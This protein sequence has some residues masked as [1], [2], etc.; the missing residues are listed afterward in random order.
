MGAEGS[1]ERN[2]RVPFNR[3]AVTGDEL[4]LV[5]EAL[6]SGQ[7]SGDGRYSHRCEQLLGEI[8]EAPGRVLL[9][10]SGTQALEMCALLI[11]VGPGDEVIG[12][13][14]TFPSTLGAFALHGA[15]PRFADISGESL[16]IDPDEIERLLGPATK[17]IVVTHYG[18]IACEMDRILELADRHGVPVVEDSAHGLFASH[19]GRPLGTMG[20]C[21]ILSFHETKNVTSGGEGGALIMRDADDLARAEM[22]REKGTNR[23]AFFR[24]EVDAY[25]WEELGSNYLLAEP[26]AAYLLAQLQARERI[27]ESRRRAW[28]VYGRELAGWAA[29]AGV[30]LPDEPANG[31]HPWHIFWMLMPDAASRDAMLVH[32]SER[33]VH[34]VFH[35][36]PLHLSPM[37]RRLAPDTG[38]L[39]VTEDVAGRIVRLP[40]HYGLSEEELD[41][42]VDAVR[43]FQP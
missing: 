7:I 12:P 3:A 37:G 30:R 9:T 38:R 42:V 4:E 34:A 43:A 24:G 13:S 28:T 2:G 11:G 25:T 22:I 6:A 16:N 15:L 18:G 20:R 36:M 29:A 1:G 35:F 33:D 17:A 21:G 5:S 26:Q 40:L 41:T 14:Y 32:L 23:A 31:R 10:P 39:P 27:Q 8:L 19:E